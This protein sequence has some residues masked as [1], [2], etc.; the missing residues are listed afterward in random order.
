M[1]E[2]TPLGRKALQTVEERAEKF[3]EKNKYG[4]YRGEVLLDIGTAHLVSNFDIEKG[5]QWLNRAAE[6]FDSARQF[7]KDLQEFELPEQV[8]RV[9]TPPKNER[10]KDRWEN[11]RLSQPKPGDLFNRRTC[12]WYFQSKQ[13]ELVLMR[14]LIAFAKNDL[15][16]ARECWGQL[17]IL[18]KDFYEAQ[19]Q[20][21]WGNAT[22]HYRLMQRIKHQPG[23]LFATTEEMNS[24]KG[25]KRRLAVLIADLYYLAEEP[26]KAYMLYQLL[27]SGTFGTLSY[28]EKAYICFA[29][30]SCMGWEPHANE[31]AY[32][33]SKLKAFVGTPSEVRTILGYAN[34]LTARVSQDDLSH[35]SNSLQKKVKAYEYLVQKFPE[36]EEAEYSTYVLGMIYAELAEDALAQQGFSTA[37]EYMSRIRKSYERQIEK[38]PSGPYISDMKLMVAR[39]N[40]YLSKRKP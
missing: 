18:D 15:E 28:N 5:E 17:T 23:A 26:R 21:G 34:R 10:F 24:F 30:F 35:G 25:T 22:T 33:E 37:L 16:P 9:S 6:W 14:G 1:W 2:K 20:N 27:E 36:T 29:K 13:K 32:I 38:N 31:I 40:S 8:R 12:E 39:I 19:A 4:L 11:V 7:D 3:L